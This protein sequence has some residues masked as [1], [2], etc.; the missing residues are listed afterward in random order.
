MW[1]CPSV[2]LLKVNFYLVLNYFLPLSTSVLSLIY[3]GYASAAAPESTS[4]P[5]ALDARAW[6]SLVGQLGLQ[7]SRG[8]WSTAVG[9]V[10][11][12]TGPTCN[13]LQTWF[14]LLSLGEGGY[15]TTFCLGWQ[16]PNLAASPQHTEQ[17]LWSETI[18]I[19]F[20]AI[21]FSGTCAWCRKRQKNMQVL[22]IASKLK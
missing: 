10:I 21:V 7:A 5:R 15:Y 12:P 1:R 22:W 18:Y 4:Q 3:T 9:P 14:I 19:H 6:P 20:C 16:Q 11:C 13:M 8:T 17:P 2:W